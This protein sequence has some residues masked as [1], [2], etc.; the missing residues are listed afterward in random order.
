[1]IR[2]LERDL[3]TNSPKEWNIMDFS[4]GASITGAG[5]GYGLLLFQNIEN[6]AIG[7]TLWAVLPLTALGV[8]LHMARKQKTFWRT[9]VGEDVT[10]DYME[11]CADEER[12]R[13][14]IKHKSVLGA[15]GQIESAIKYISEIDKR[16][17]E[18]HE[19]I[20]PKFGVASILFFTTGLF[21]KAMERLGQLGRPLDVFSSYLIGLAASILVVVFFMQ[22]RSLFIGRRTKR[23]RLYRDLVEA[24]AFIESG[25]CPAPWLDFHS[26]KTV[27]IAAVPQA[28]PIKSRKGRRAKR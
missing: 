14:V 8:V 18:W 28:A 27:S 7:G 16:A 15:I 2:E 23:R 20:V 21:G 26:P 6:Q 11:A 5:F 22:T 24:R 25:K 4:T 12:A 1:M 13:R 9:R 19:P 3:S 10:T 17:V